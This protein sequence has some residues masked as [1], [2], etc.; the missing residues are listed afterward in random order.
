[1][2]CSYSGLPKAIANKRSSVKRVDQVA[3]ATTFY[4]LLD[5]AI[6][7]LR[8][9]GPHLACDPV[10]LVKVN[11]LAKAF[12]EKVCIYVY[13]N[14]KIGLHVLGANISANHITMCFNPSLF[15]RFVTQ[16]TVQHLKITEI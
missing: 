11:R 12:M 4:A 15:Y 7:M 6:P 10:L 14:I 1:M 16:S 2:L 3:Q 9:L 5:S 13:C 8:H